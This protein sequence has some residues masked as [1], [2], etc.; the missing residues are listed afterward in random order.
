MLDL[1]QNKLYDVAAMAN[2]KVLHSVKD[3]RL[4]KRWQNAIIRALV[5]IE[6]ASEFMHYDQRDNALV[7][8]SQK[9]NAIYEANGVCQCRA[10]N[11]GQPCWHRAAARLVKLYEETTH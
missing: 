5:E 4:A 3:S 9:S 8:W 1:D 10:F 11:E 7:I 2:D 6:V